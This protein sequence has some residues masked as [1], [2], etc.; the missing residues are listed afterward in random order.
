MARHGW[1][2]SMPK[3]HAGVILSQ[4]SEILSNRLIAL[5]I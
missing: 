5:T 2:L 4:I 1:G 3:S